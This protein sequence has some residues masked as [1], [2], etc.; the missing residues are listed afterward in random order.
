MRALQRLVELSLMC[1]RPAIVMANT[2]NL[3]HVLTPEFLQWVQTLSPQDLTQ[4]RLRFQH[5]Q[6]GAAP[7]GGNGLEPLVRSC[8]PRVMFQGQIFVAEFDREA[9]AAIDR[10]LD[11]IAAA[12]A[13]PGSHWEHSEYSSRSH[14]SSRNIRRQRIFARNA[15]AKPSHHGW[16]ESIQCPAPSLCALRY[17]G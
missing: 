2:L 6:S 9:A 1:G 10:L 13:I 8:V 17:P 12:Q 7:S 14:N 15:R 4:G 16:S 5:M 3:T 11:I